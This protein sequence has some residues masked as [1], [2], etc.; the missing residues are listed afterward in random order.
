MPTGAVND[1]PPGLNRS[2]EHT[3]ELQSPC[4]FVCRLLLEKK[5]KLRPTF[6]SSIRGLFPL[7]P[8]PTHYTQHAHRVLFLSAI[9]HASQA[10]Y[11]VTRLL[12]RCKPLQRL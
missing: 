6:A 12:P 5:K 10:L 2:E 11:Y 7:E 8:L 1:T 9:S 3:S 4:N